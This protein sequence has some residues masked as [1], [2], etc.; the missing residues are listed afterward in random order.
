M[1][2]LGQ[3]TQDL[4][5]LRLKLAEPFGAD[6]AQLGVR[7]D[8]LVPALEALAEFVA[9]AFE[10]PAL[11]GGLLAQNALIFDES[12]QDS[13]QRSAA[14]TCL[15][16]WL[17]NALSSVSTPIRYPAQASLPVRR[18]A[19]SCSNDRVRRSESCSAERRV[20]VG[21]LRSLTEVAFG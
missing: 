19:G 20:R 13:W 16:M 9:L 15:A 11:F 5:A 7:F 10:E 17:T 8:A 6:V 18:N 21:R 14:N 12:A 2:Q 3:R 4:V 1:L